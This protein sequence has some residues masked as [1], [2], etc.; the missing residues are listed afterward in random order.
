MY[1][2][3]FI[4]LPSYKPDREL[5]LPTVK[6]LV[7]SFR[8]VV[9]ID[10]GGGSEYAKVFEEVKDLGAIVLTHYINSGK[11]RALKTALNYIFSNYKNVDAIV[12][13]D[14]DG[15]HT[16]EDIEKIA[17]KT[18]ENQ[19]AYVLGAR[20]F[21]E[22]KIPLRSRFGNVLTRNIFKIFIGLTITDT[23]TGLR[24]MSLEVAKELYKV[25]GERYEYET[26]TLI[27]C[28]ENDIPLVEETISTIY[29]DDNNSSHFNPIKDSFI[30]YKLFFKYIFASAS[31]FL[32]DLL[33]FTIFLKVFNGN[34]NAAF[35]ST[36][37]ARI[38]SSL[39]NYFIN[40]KLVFKKQNKTSLIKYFILVVVAMLLSAFI[41][42]ILSKTYMSKIILIKV[43]VDIV[44]FIINFI[45]QREWVFKQ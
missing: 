24:G 23:Q 14:G 21:S 45:V 31:S 38:L 11:G 2:N 34:T 12:T 36:V 15:Q 35:I 4:V 26:N 29:I 40:S 30:I 18:V 10:D 37:C 43:I 9:V 42:N 19:N 6:G 3:V 1:N 5:L 20:N 32:L 27:A 16:L 8:Y 33:L 22:E 13:A 28:K 44:I 39:Y 41:V 7:N 17:K 25:S